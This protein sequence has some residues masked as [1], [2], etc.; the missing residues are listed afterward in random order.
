MNKT[1]L[2]SKAFYGLTIYIET[3][4][5]WILSSSGDPHRREKSDPDQ[6]HC[7]KSDTDQHQ[8]K[9]DFLDPH[10]SEKLDPDPHQGDVDPQ[11]C[12]LSLDPKKAE[13]STCRNLSR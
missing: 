1:T 7:E 9:S 6:R 5:I 13:L 2:K 11:Y 3:P 10:Q 8:S 4:G 12:L